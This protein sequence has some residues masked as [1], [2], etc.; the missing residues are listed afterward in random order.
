MLKSMVRLFKEEEGQGLVEYVLIMSLISL[1]IMATMT[2]LRNNIDITYS[3]S[4]NTLG[5]L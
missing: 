5:G 1:A 3:N 4:A 2:L